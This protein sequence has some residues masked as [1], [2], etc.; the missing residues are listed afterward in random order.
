M[1]IS[2]W[3]S[4]V[5]SSDLLA[6]PHERLALPPI[7]LSSI[8]LSRLAVS[9]HKDGYGAELPRTCCDR[10]IARRG[11]PGLEC[12]LQVEQ[13]TGAPNAKKGPL[14]FGTVGNGV[15]PERKPSSGRAYGKRSEEH[16]S[17]LQ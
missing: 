9:M 7:E 4:D 10:T 15:P 13:C 8:L 16:T 2:D 1:R 11:L 17:E 6:Y 12:I 14:S 3:S 5:C